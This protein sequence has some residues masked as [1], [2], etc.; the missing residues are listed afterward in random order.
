MHAPLS[1][2][3]LYPPH[4]APSAKPLRFP[5]NIAKL[6]VNNLKI[7]PEQAYHEPVVISPGPPRVA[8]FTGTDAVKTLLFDR[9]AD[10]PKGALQRNTLKPMLGNAMISCEGR[11]WRW[12]RSAAAPL[13][14]YD[15]LLRYGP[16]FA[17]AAQNTI[18]RWRA[19]APGTVH[20]IHS[21]MLRAGFHVISNTML[22]GGAPELLEAIGKGQAGY[23]EAA[24][25]RV[26]YTILNLPHWLPRPGKRIMQAHEKRL[27]DAVSALVRARRAR[28]ADGDDLLGRLVRASDPETGQSM[29]DELVADNIIAFLLAGND[30]M[31]FSLI[32]TLYLVAQSPEWEARMLRE[33]E[34]VAGTGPVTA[35]HVA[36]LVTVQQVLNESMRLYPTAPI[37]VRDLPED[38]E[39]DGVKVP[40]GTIGVI[41]IYAIQRHRDYWEDPHRF[42]PGRFGPDRP[43]P[44]R[45]QFLPFGAGPRICIGAAFAMI[46]GTI[47]LAEFVRAARFAVEPG[48]DPQPSARMFL[49]PRYGMPLR[50]T[51]RDV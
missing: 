25:W 49:L 16:I 1:E 30:T 47:M 7:I 31:S 34:E 9:A 51:M 41:P 27:R 22:A 14:R 3:P 38:V 50:V 37:I 13:F 11:E 5:V 28:A 21:D 35:E 44:G 6:L 12:Q 17:D 29:S 24:N 39:F 43:K 8:F 42:D 48:F 2:I 26:A 4:V 19:A 36:K 10:F 18:A 32:W 45:F 33:I 46:E 20:P 40:A 15:E 23:Y